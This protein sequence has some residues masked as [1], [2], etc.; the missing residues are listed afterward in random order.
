MKLPGSRMYVDVTCTV[1][2]SLAS[3][4]ILGTDAI[5]RLIVS[6]VNDS[7]VVCYDTSVTAPMTSDESS[8]QTEIDSDIDT[9]DV[10]VCQINDTIIADADVNQTDDVMNG[11]GIIS[12]VEND[13]INGAVNKSVNVRKA[14]A[15]TLEQEQLAYKSLQLCWSLAERGKSNYFVRDCILYRMEKIRGQEFE[16]L[17]LPSGRWA[18]AIKLS[19]KTFG[20]T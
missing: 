9:D 10:S 19:H 14:S 6:S 17:C 15:D 18:E 4:L 11:D 16:Q 13:D 3:E 1:C 7:D 5:Q 2:E 8:N 12:D 20:V